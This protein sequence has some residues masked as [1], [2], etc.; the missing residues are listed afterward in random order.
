MIWKHLLHLLIWQYH[1]QRLTYQSLH[2]F[3]FKV[4]TAQ[5]EKKKIMPEMTTDKN[6]QRWSR[7]FL[8]R[9]RG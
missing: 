9:E 8:F 4:R 6:G 3:V 2:K 5:K 1:E 7:V